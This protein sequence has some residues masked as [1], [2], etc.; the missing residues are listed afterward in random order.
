M[1]EMSDETLADYRQLVSKSAAEIF[2][3]RAQVARLR[4]AGDRLFAWCAVNATAGQQELAGYN[5]VL[6]AWQDARRD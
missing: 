2:C 5:E 3:L 1:P 4:A 6:D